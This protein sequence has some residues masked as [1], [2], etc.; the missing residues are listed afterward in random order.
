MPIKLYEHQKKAV[1]KLHNG[2]I[3]VGGVG[4]GKSITSLAYYYFKV[5]EGS[6]DKDGILP[7]QKPR[8]LVIITTAL[9]RDSREWDNECSNFLICNDPEIN[10]NHTSVTIDSWNN[11]GKYIGVKDAFF[12]FDEQRLVGSGAWA[13]AF[14]KI[15]KNNQWILLSATPGDTWTDYTQVFIANGFYKNK[16]QFEAR[17]C[18]YNPYVK[19]K[20]IMRYLDEGVLLKYRRIITVE[21]PFER[22]TIP[23]HETLISSYD[24]TKYFIIMKE[25]W[26]PYE[27]KPIRNVSELC[28]LL[29]KVSVT[30]PSRIEIVKKLIRMHGK[31][32][33]F[34]NYN[35][36]LEL[37]RTMVEEI[38]IP[39]GEWNGQLHTKV[40]E[41]DSWV[42]LV[43]YN[44][45]A[46]GWNCTT[47][48]TL[49]FYSEPYSYK[50][51]A[52]AAGRIDRMNTPF[53][54]LYYYHIRSNSSIERAVSSTL[55]KKKQFNES[56]FISFPK[57]EV[58]A[59]KETIRQKRPTTKTPPDSDS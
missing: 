41:G 14:Q 46:E 13:K 55:A 35:C 52:Q 12:I 15:V 18:V 40:P 1:E 53:T 32:I 10:F 25:R 36:E 44:A 48:D 58:N 22:H 49:I 7:M 4:S 26:N 39:Y 3:L 2:S 16:T 59:T 6:M 33:I 17:H 47:T 21:M 56:K 29:R 5:C 37:L 28:M 11:I 30:D 42:Y 38:D 8:D 34:Y 9:K 50:K 45:G 57:E 20:Q 31:A 23:K 43:Q 19:F 27:D 24:K 54:T 51:L